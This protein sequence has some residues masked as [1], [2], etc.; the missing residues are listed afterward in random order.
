MLTA[1]QKEL[2]KAGLGG[3]DAAVVVGL[4]PFKS[5][6]QLWLEK[7][8]EVL[9]NEEETLAMKFGN[10]LEEPIAQHYCDVTGRTVRRQPMAVHTEYPFMLANI[11]RQILKDPRG[12][13]ILEVKTTNEWSGKQIHGVTDIPDHWYLQMQHYLAVY[14]YAWAS[15]AILVG[16]QRFVHFD[17]ERNEEVIR[18]L[19]RQET[20][21]WERVMT[22]NPLPVDGS[23][24]TGELIKKLYP[25][26]TGKIITMDAPELI[27]SAQQLIHL[28]QIAKQA[29]EEVG[30]YENRLKSAM[31]D[32]S[33]AILPGF[34]RLT[35]KCAK[36][37]ISE[38]LD[39]EK[40]KAAYPDIYAACLTQK[41]R[42]GGRRFLIKPEV[43]AL[44]THTHT[45]KE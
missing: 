35:W 5:P 43:P 10:L 41:V 20:E 2:R 45:I 44:P 12:P 23:A 24:R 28:K 1:E 18:E 25:R 34:G 42:P 8:G 26:D 40:L 19:I 4:S 7:R 30:L 37:S 11:D 3:S 13:G 36:D 33:E 31:G 39:V 17:V 16:G 29:E 27:D 6:Y 14:G 22:N 9:P 38:S 15:C 21:F 32:A